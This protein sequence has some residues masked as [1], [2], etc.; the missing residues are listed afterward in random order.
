MRDP[1]AA[2]R[3]E[4]ERALVAFALE[5][6]STPH[7]VGEEAV[8]ALRRAGLDDRAV[9]DLVLVV[10]YFNFVNRLAAGLGVP[11]EEEP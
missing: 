1:V 11:L 8:A 4:R 7:R 2:A 6:T 3:N 10:A 5:L 9:V